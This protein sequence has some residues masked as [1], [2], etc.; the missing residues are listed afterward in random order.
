L[1]RAAEHGPLEFLRRLLGEVAEPG[2]LRHHPVPALG[3]DLAQ[4]D[5]EARRLAGAVRPNERDTV[6]RAD[7]P[8]DPLEEDPCADRVSNVVQPDQDSPSFLGGERRSATTPCVQGSED[9]TLRRDFL[10]PPRCGTMGPRGASVPRIRPPREATLNDPFLKEESTMKWRNTILIV[11]VSALAGTAGCGGDIVQQMMTNAETKA[12]VTD[13]IV[14]DQATAGEMVDKLINT[15]SSRG[16]VMEKLMANGE[17]V[18]GI[19]GRI[20]R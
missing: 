15:E 20:A 6:P 8:V 19:M 16:I 5:L 9:S 18:Q 3:R 4:H 17:M 7:Q 13:A 11:L 2:S 14:A 12:K 10:P 1:E